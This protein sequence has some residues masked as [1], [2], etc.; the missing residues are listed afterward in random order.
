MGQ[1]SRWGAF[2]I[3][4]FSFDSQLW[5]RDFVL[6][7]NPMTAVSFVII[8]TRCRSCVGMETVAGERV[9]QPARY[10]PFDTGAPSWWLVQLWLPALLATAIIALWC[11][12]S[13]PAPA[14]TD[15]LY[16]SLITAVGWIEFFLI[17]F[18]LIACF[19]L[20]RSSFP[21]FVLRLRMPDTW[22][23]T[24]SDLNLN[25]LGLDI[26]LGPVIRKGARYLHLAR[27]N[28]GKLYGK[29]A[30]RPSGYVA[31]WR[32]VS[33]VEPP[34]QLSTASASCGVHTY[35]SG[36]R[37]EG[38]LRRGRC[39][40]SGVYYFSLRG[41]YEGEWVDGKYDGHGVETWSQGSR[42]KGQYRQGLREGFGVYRFYT[43]DVYS[44]MWCQGQSHGVGV[45]MCADGSQYVGEFAW[46]VKHGCGKYL[47]RNGDVYS[48]EYFGE[49]MHGFGVYRFATLQSYAGAWYEGRKQGLGVYIFSNGET[50]AGV[51]HRGALERRSTH[52]IPS[53][54]DTQRP[55]TLHN[56]A[57]HTSVSN[58][59]VLH[60][61]QVSLSPP[62]VPTTADVTADVACPSPGSSS[63]CCQGGWGGSGGGA[64]AESGGCCK[65]FCDGGTGDGGEGHA[66]GGETTHRRALR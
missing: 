45:Q 10:P 59:R 27:L 55:S 6:C 30:R 14:T 51:W 9:L 62:S 46:G 61:L 65:P 11:L 42:Y 63:R 43:G 44:G 1:T 21:D 66:E 5:P 39:S 57:S 38:E 20:A 19:L 34:P 12:R 33:G 56:A 36:E 29:A 23:A 13:M 40:G 41:R 37:Y 25:L 60:A 15:W 18:L 32:T 64:R 16:P 24:V 28:T 22:Q 4:T 2:L 48:G 35:A 53:T 31:S 58:T 50:R 47:F 3:I 8:R 54:P 7:H 52:S 49:R 17:T 26:R